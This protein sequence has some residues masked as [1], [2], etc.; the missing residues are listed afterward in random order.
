MKVNNSIV[1]ALALSII[2]MP[3]IAQTTK[4]TSPTHKT[5][6]K[7]MYLDVHQLGKVKL[8][9]VAG[10][11]AKDLAVEK[12]YGVHFIKY[13]VNPDKG[14]VMC[15]ASAPDSSSLTKTH[16]EAHGLL[17]EHIYKL[18]NATASTLK[19]QKD[20]FLDVHYLGAGK[21]TAKDAAEA[22]KKDLAVQEKHGVVFVDYWVDEKEGTVRC[23]VQAKDSASVAQTHK[24]A[25]GLIPNEIVK[26]Q[27]GNQEYAKLPE[28]KN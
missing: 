22:H 9:D 11:H 3:V 24:E 4:T 23:L 21:I 16:S 20:F 17:P 2:S 13:W 7:N 28:R 1:A 19:D 14:L 10:A 6:A 18:N 8:E 5:A 15:L 12:K 27:L 25:H 26:L